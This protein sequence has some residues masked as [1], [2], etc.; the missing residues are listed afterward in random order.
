MIKSDETKSFKIK[1]RMGNIIKHIKGQTGFLNSEQKS[2]GDDFLNH[3]FRR[4]IE[5]IIV[6]LEH[7]LEKEENKVEK[8]HPE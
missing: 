4:E 5:K 7:I 3:S 2:L 1:K 6:N 8:A